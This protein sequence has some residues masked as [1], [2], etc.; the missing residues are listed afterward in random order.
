MSEDRNEDSVEEA[1]SLLTGP[2]AEE[3]APLHRAELYGRLTAAEWTEAQIAKRVGR[4]QPHVHKTLSFLQLSDRLRSLVEA[5]A[6]SATLAV[7]LQRD[8]GANAAGI[9][10][11]A[12]ALAHGKRRVT[13]R[14][15]AAALSASPK[16]LSDEEQLTINARLLPLLW[17]LD[18]AT[19]TPGRPGFLS[20]TLPREEVEALQALRGM[21]A[22]KP[23][24]GEQGREE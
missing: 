9:V 22:L 4:S 5:G 14:D 11:Q 19:P 20:V 2:Q 10:R 17:H 18:H 13:A 7:T 6:V 24:G 16:S 3:L 1:L 15:I 23:A 8:H 21:L 12:Q